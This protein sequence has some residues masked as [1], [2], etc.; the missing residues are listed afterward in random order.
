[1]VM[2][3]ERVELFH[4]SQRLVTPFVTSFGGSQERQALLLALHA[5]G[6]TG[7]GECVANSDPGYSYETV[8]T[9]WHI[10]SDF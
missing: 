2:K 5:D 7:W 8:H 10:L 4:I 1:M 6:L 9:A 3:I